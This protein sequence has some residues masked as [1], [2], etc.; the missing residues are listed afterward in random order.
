MRILDAEE[1]ALLLSSTRIGRLAITERALPVLLP[2]VFACVDSDVVFGVGPGVVARAAAAG[3]IVCFEADGADS[4]FTTMWSVAMTGPL[5]VVDTP[6]DTPFDTPLGTPLD[7]AVTARLDVGPW[8]NG[9]RVF[10][11]LSVALCNGRSW[12][13]ASQPMPLPDQES[14]S[15]T[16]DVF[17][18]AAT[19]VGVSASE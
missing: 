15:P 6:L 16:I 10:V 4:E 13:A 8:T 7:E 9:S 2:V 12:T 1:C 19:K 17:D 14:S 3:Q 11:R 5:C 18:T